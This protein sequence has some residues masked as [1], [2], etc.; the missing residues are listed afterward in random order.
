MSEPQIREDMVKVEPETD[1]DL[2]P[3]TCH[4]K[5]V[6]GTDLRASVSGRTNRDPSPHYPL[7]SFS[8]EST[9]RIPPGASK[10]L[11]LAEAEKIVT[12]KRQKKK[13]QK[14]TRCEDAVKQT[15]VGAPSKAEQGLL[16]CE[17][18]DHVAF[19]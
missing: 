2:F 19:E 1:D 15:D 8:Q 17:N 12:N 16:D 6:T 3:C 18:S 10:Q 13:T 4:R 5:K 11:I 14:P 9:T 7:K